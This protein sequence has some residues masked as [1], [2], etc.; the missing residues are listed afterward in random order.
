M[1][2]N[3]QKRLLLYVL[4]QLSLFS[5]I[6][7][8]NL[9]EVSLNNILLRNVSLDPEKVGKLPGFNLRYG[10]VGTL[11]LN[12]GVMGGVN[13]DARDVE[14]VIA[15]SLDN[16]D[17]HFS[18]AQSTADLANMMESMEDDNENPDDF[19]DSVDSNDPDRSNDNDNDD[20]DTNNDDNE[21]QEP[22][23]ALGGV[24]AKAVE[25]ALQKL[26]FKISNLVI[27]VILEEVDMA[28]NVGIIK[29]TTA[30]GIKRIK[31]EQ[32]SVLTTKPNVPPGCAP[33]NSKQQNSENE[34][35][36]ESEVH[37]SSDEDSDNSMDDGEV[38]GSKL[39][40]SMVF[41]REEASSIYMSATSRSFNKTASTGSTYFSKIQ[42]STI[43]YIDGIDFTF[44]GLTSMSHMNIDIGNINVAM[45]PT[46]PTIIAVISSMGQNSKFRSHINPKKDPKVRNDR[47]PQ[48]TDDDVNSNETESSDSP[49][50]VFD[51][52]HISSINISTSSAL[53]SNGQF[54]S[55]SGLRILL[56]NLNV[57]QRD[58][59]LLFGGIEDVAL[60]FDDGVHPRETLS[61]SDA[62][63][64]N[65]KSDKSRADFR[66][67]YSLENGISEFT[68][69]ISKPCSVKL[70]PDSV[71]NIVKLV[72]SVSSVIDNYQQL[73]AT[74]KQ[75][76]KKEKSSENTTYL[77]LQTA[78]FDVDLEFEEGTNVNVVVFPISFSTKSG[79][80]KIDRI[81]LTLHLQTVKYPLLTWQ[82]LEFLITEK[83][84]N[85]FVK[86]GHNPKN[87]AKVTNVESSNSVH[88]SRISAQIQY[89]RL[90]V[91]LPSI[92]E[93]IERIGSHFSESDIPQ[94]TKRKPD[95]S[96]SVS[97]YS[98]ARR[99]GNVGVMPNIL[100]GNYRNLAASF[101]VHISKIRCN[102]ELDR[103]FGSLDLKLDQCVAFKTKDDFYGSILQ[104]LSA[105]SLPS[106]LTEFL[107]SDITELDT[108]A[109]NPLVMFN[110]RN[111][112]KLN[113]LDVHF[114]RLKLEY[115]ASWVSLLNKLEP[116]NLS[117][118]SGDPSVKNMK[119]FDTYLS[120]NDCA[121]AFNPGRLRSK[122]VAVIESCTSDVR[123]TDNQLVIK[124]TL[125]DIGLH[126]LDD[127]NNRKKYLS[128]LRGGLHDDPSP[129]KYFAEIGFLSLGALNSLHVG[130]ATEKSRLGEDIVDIKVNA[131]EIQLDVCADSF[132]TLV[133]LLNDMTDPVSLE[134]NEKS[135]VTVDKVNLLSNIEEH[136]MQ[137][138]NA[139]QGDSLVNDEQGNGSL[140]A[141]ES[142]LPTK[143]SICEDHFA[144]GSGIE[145]EESNKI[146]MNINLGKAIIY[147]Y[148]GY[149]WKLT[150]KGIKGAI[151]R[152]E[153]ELL[154][155]T[156][157]EPQVEK[158]NHKVSFEGDKPVNVIEETLY[159]SIHLSVPADSNAEDLT[160]RINYQILTNNSTDPK[161][162]SSKAYKNLHLRRSKQQ[163]VIV[164]LSDASAEVKIFS[165]RDPHTQPYQKSLEHEVMNSID[166]K[167][168]TF[169]I[170]DNVPTS[171]WN[172]FMTYMNILGK[173]EHGT[174]MARLKLVN[175][176]PDP[177]LI[178]TEAVINLEL[179][180]IRMYIDQD[181]LDFLNRFFDFND[182]RF[183]LPPDEILYIQR[184]SIGQ[185]RL[186]LDYKP[187]GINYTGMRSGDASE[188]MHIFVLD[189]SDLSLP[190]TVLYGIHGIP[191]L[192]LALGNV[193]GPVIQKTQLAGL[194]AGI[195]PLKSFVNLGG[196]FKD[197]VA[198]PIA[199]YKRDG[200]LANSIRKGTFAF[201]KSTTAELLRLGAKLSSGTQVLLENSE[202]YLGGEGSQARNPRSRRDS[203][204]DDGG[205][206]LVALTTKKAASDIMATSQ[207]LQK[208]A[209]ADKDMHK[210]PRA[211]LFADID[212]S[213]EFDPD[214]L[215]DALVDLN[216]DE[217]EPYAV[218]EDNVAEDP[219]SDIEVIGGEEDKVTSLYSNQPVTSKEGLKKAY[220]SIGRNLGATGDTISKLKEDIAH[221]DNVP[222]SL[223]AI[224]KSS[225]I[226][227][228]RPIIG[229][230]EALLKV[231]MGLSNEIDDRY[232][233]E[234]KDKY[235][236][237][238]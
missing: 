186:K 74:G 8:P 20:N 106:N 41:T 87:A 224:A 142:E 95:L 114:S 227:L 60:V 65:K 237:D 34:V 144:L 238:E 168:N 78:A 46:I 230:T 163:K 30:D 116:L 36:D 47:F 160:T 161:T 9:E 16:N 181:T 214:L 98:S 164:E 76:S 66:F 62:E 64:S 83:T 59:G 57:V 120:F 104:I 88:I 139:A 169:D 158:A 49:D 26:Q 19:D 135:K 82:S 133:Q 102:L 39:M 80:L 204:E 72:K 213:G 12:G 115:H 166:L 3:I 117:T 107:V 1:P 109:R 69:L 37:E 134:E 191:K 176:R 153:E 177:S 162:Q 182:V 235:K 86:S 199:E 2:Q 156:R 105:R 124:S 197:L 43:A 217:A 10:Q 118:G 108:L 51:K 29:M 22:R 35:E 5:E 92:Q 96:M 103:N 152:V 155:P 50:N 215:H 18:L 71:M 187:K 136:F 13:V 122:C 218:D 11:E 209:T 89:L 206:F 226:I 40:D 27:K 42:P 31:V 93:L 55:T 61:F 48:Y 221:A 229:T 195:A 32:I 17:V 138:V 77:T 56:E 111:R 223:A 52:L 180:P 128:H 68:F 70:C 200:R 232:V 97:H 189:G 21:T 185:V 210:K 145:Q 141:L 28:I 178:A 113:A 129:Q 201:A 7:L 94:T 212:E 100:M 121:V 202:K 175:V 6:D 73:F 91:L 208:K 173:R 157:E 90:V 127:V 25:I 183:D 171:T 58:Q 132:H 233:V 154:S 225:P 216:L 85:A 236:Q 194:L 147:L 205:K 149:D 4:Q 190:P 23:S 38:E 196:N 150:R 198:I 45:V 125:K 99:R 33:S 140:E 24:M 174:H 110:L 112:D 165:T 81:V 179:L 192:G 234:N 148:D 63:P 170:I 184:F 131:D 119:R 126:L 130:I 123:L 67:E 203:V 172:K 15:P 79:G 54:A 222:D 101:S 53:D 159:K 137:A 143:L 84:F 207:L 188:F 151:R 14:V 228:M 44:E 219:E 193:W 167:L 211:Y 146:E 220:Q 75:G 231:L